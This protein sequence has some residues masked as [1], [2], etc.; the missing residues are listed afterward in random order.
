MDRPTPSRSIIDDLGYVIVYLVLPI[1]LVFSTRSIP[2]FVGFG[3]AGLAVAM[4]R[5]GRLKRW[6]AAMKGFALSPI[7]LAGIVLLAW[8]A[9]NPHLGSPIGF[10][11][12]AWLKFALSL[13]LVVAWAGASEVAGA[14]DRARLRRYQIAGL[15][16]VGA[17]IIVELNTYSMLRVSIGLNR[18]AR[19]PTARS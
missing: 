1:G 19:S 4:A 6:P 12:N 10:D 7:G 5:N 8:A 15:L 3:I 16:I 18:E 14:P 9:L 13:G 2:L 11:F 17:I